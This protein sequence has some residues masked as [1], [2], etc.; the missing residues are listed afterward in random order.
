MPL[1]KAATAPAAAAGPA[2]L[3]NWPPA[4]VDPASLRDPSV[5]G[6]GAEAA[7]TTTPCKAPLSA[8]SDWSWTLTSSICAHRTACE[9]S[10]ASCASHAAEVRSHE[11]CM[12]EIDACMSSRNAALRPKPTSPSS[13][14]CC[15]SSKEAWPS[16]FCCFISSVVLPPP[17]PSRSRI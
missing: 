10:G 3:T 12:A 2:F 5:A 17:S 13:P 11:S 16:S 14:S 15:S 9:A 1:S 4:V 8:A 6:P 7:A